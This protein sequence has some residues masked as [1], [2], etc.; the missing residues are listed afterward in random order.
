MSWIGVAPGATVFGGSGFR[1]IEPVTAG[2]GY[3]QAEFGI[4]IA[5][6]QQVYGDDDTWLLLAGRYFFH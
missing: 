2:V 1:G 3:V 5:L 6:R 4:D